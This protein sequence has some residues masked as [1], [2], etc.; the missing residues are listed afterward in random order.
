MPRGAFVL[1]PHPAASEKI[2]QLKSM[3]LN[4]DARMT[5]DGQRCVRLCPDILNTEDELARA[6]R[7]I[8]KAW[9]P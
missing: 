9:H 3:G 7:L 2:A 4:T 5:P 6:A 1:V 8:A